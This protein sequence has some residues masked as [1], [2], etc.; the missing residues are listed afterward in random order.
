MTSVNYHVWGLGD[1]KTESL[2]CILES[3]HTDKNIEKIKTILLPC[4]DL[5]EWSLQVFGSVNYYQGK[6]AFS[7]KINFLRCVRNAELNEILDDEHV[8]IAVDFSNMQILGFTQLIVKFANNNYIDHQR[9]L[10]NSLKFLKT[11]APDLIPQTIDIPKVIN[12][13]QGTKIN[14]K[15]PLKIGNIELHWIGAHAEKIVHEGSVISIVGMKVKMYNPQNGLWSWVV[16]GQEGQIIT[17]ERDVYWNF[18][19]FRRDTQMWLHSKWVIMHNILNQV[20]I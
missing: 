6:K 4:V 15:K 2:E 14:F 16:V 7:R 20:C 1:K 3:T 17:Y 18:L 11:F 10:E 5:N 9:A 8:S 12:Q 19:K 13:A